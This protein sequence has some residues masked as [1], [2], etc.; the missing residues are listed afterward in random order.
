[1]QSPDQIA[2]TAEEDAQLAG[3]RRRAFVGS[4]PEVAGRI[5]DLAAELGLAEIVVNTWA[6]DPDVRRQS[7]ALLAREFG[8]A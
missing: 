5:R 3:M 6:H 7:Y 8:L 4:A 1:L 2:F